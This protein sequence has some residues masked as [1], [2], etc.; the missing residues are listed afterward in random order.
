MAGLRTDEDGL[1]GFVVNRGVA[2]GVRGLR[3]SGQASECGQRIVENVGG[4]FCGE[5]ST[6]PLKRQM[7]QMKL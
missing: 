7:G 1:L 5:I 3:V 4:T 2:E 6:G